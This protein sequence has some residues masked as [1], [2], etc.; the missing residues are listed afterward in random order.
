MFNHTGIPAPFYIL[1]EQL[2]LW[3]NI[4]NLTKCQWPSRKEQ[5][6]VVVSYQKKCVKNK[7]IPINYPTQLSMAKLNY[8]NPIDYK[9]KD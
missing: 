1:E 7:N 9:R 2:Y 6:V 3:F 8:W 4:W 5:V